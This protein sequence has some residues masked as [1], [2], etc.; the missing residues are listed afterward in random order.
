MKNLRITELRTLLEDL[1]L[2]AVIDSHEDLNQ[3]NKAIAAIN[4]ELIQLEEPEVYAQNKSH[5]DNYE[6]RF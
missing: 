5:F 6:R 1:Q 4:F 3:Y 2:N